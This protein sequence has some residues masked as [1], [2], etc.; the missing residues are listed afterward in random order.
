V[1]DYTKTTSRTGGGAQEPPQP[2]RAAEPER[3]PLRQ[4]PNRSQPLTDPMAYVRHDHEQAAAQIDSKLLAWRKAAGAES[5]AAGPAVSQPGEPAELEADAVADRVVG[6]L[7][8]NDSGEASNHEATTQAAPAI[9]AK[10]KAGAISLA[11]K[12]DKKD[13]EHGTPAELKLNPP[14]DRHF[15]AKIA[16]T[17]LADVNTV[18]A[19]SVDVRADMADIRS[20]KAKAGRTAGGERQYTVNGRTYGVHPN[21]TMY[22]MSGQG[23]FQLDRAGYQLLVQMKAKG[24]WNADTERFAKGR[25]VPA[26]QVALAKA[27]YAA[28]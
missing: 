9:G 7:H 8:G 15:F 14:A 17:Y 13:E 4:M 3:M 27:A 22:P 6:E 20:G 5:K 11:R 12:D 23:L 21:G 26:D 18:I 24:G 28:K 2:P 25:G 19:S 16:S 1:S 10:L